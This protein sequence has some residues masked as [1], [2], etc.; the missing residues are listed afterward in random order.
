[1]IIIDKLNLRNPNFGY[2]LTN[3][4]EGTRGWTINEETR[5]KFRNRQKGKMG[6]LSPHYGKKHTQEAK[7]NM[8]ISHRG[9]SHIYQYTKQGECVGEFEYPKIASEQTGIGRSA[10][11]NCLCGLSYTAGG[12]IWAET[13]DDKIISQIVDKINKNKIKKTKKVSN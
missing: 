13:N 8:S 1:M 12:Y 11:A 4:G 2:N 7:I 10:I 3:G 9:A 6:E 5:Q